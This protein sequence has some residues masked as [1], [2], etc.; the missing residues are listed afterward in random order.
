M[1]FRSA[2]HHDRGVRLAGSGGRDAP[3]GPKGHPGPGAQTE[4]DQIGRLRRRWG[5]QD[6]GAAD[7]PAPPGARRDSVARRRGRRPC[8][9][10]GRGT[11][12]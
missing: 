7:D 11:K 5:R 9:G 10:P 8:R 12:E 4:P 6:P 3:G 2:Q 1:L